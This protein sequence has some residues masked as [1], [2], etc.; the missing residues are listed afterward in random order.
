M[1][2]TDGSQGGFNTAD[3]GETSRSNNT[4][5]S[6]TPPAKRTSRGSERDL[7]DVLQ[8]HP[9][10]GFVVESTT[11]STSEFRVERALA[12][13]QVAQPGVFRRPLTVEANAEQALQYTVGGPHQLNPDRL[14]PD[15]LQPGTVRHAVENGLPVPPLPVPRSVPIMGQVSAPQGEPPLPS[16]TDVQ[17]V[18]PPVPQPQPLQGL[19][20]RSMPA[21][22]PPQP[23]G[24]GV[25]HGQDR[26]LAQ[27]LDS[28][29]GTALSMIPEQ[30]S[31]SGATRSASY[32]TG[33]SQASAL[34]SNTHGS[35]SGG[36]GVQAFTPAYPHLA[37]PAGTSVLAI[38]Q[39]TQGEAPRHP[40]NASVSSIA[41]GLSAQTTTWV[42][43]SNTTDPSR[44]SWSSFY[45]QGQQP[46]APAPKRVATRQGDSRGDAIATPGASGSNMNS[47]A[48]LVDIARG[49]MRATDSGQ[50]SMNQYQNGYGGVP[51]PVH[52]DRDATVSSRIRTFDQNTNA[53]NVP[54]VPQGPLATTP[55]MGAS[56]P[57]RQTQPGQTS[58]PRDQLEA[59]RI[60]DA[61]QREIDA[62]LQA[63]R[64]QAARGPHRGT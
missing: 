56:Q 27:L 45:D 41:S 9:L 20:P 12:L 8:P 35:D 47:S 43:F 59:Q 57:V 6:P 38:M 33:S 36:H 58:A 62:Q 63:E 42:G 64:E 19:Q 40:S 14:R 55:F 49:T 44:S 28:A 15:D 37:S 26:P 18:R 46:A 1:S 21:A 23:I 22:L 13:G 29:P 17:N 50:S 25:G 32:N 4:S 54:P 48:S 39:G 24:H 61:R 16:L 34:S 2:D 30:P 11:H 51:A 31:Q 53:S 5:R 3:S 7:R 10:Q 52:G 60:A